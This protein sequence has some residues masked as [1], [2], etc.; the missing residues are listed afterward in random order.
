MFD[1]ANLEADQTIENDDSSK[2]DEGVDNQVNSIPEWKELVVVCVVAFKIHHLNLSR[3]IGGFCHI[4]FCKWDLTV[5]N[6]DV[7]V[8]QEQSDDNE[9]LAKNDM[10]Y[11]L[12]IINK[13]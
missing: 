8:H 4:V 7:Q 1:C 5:E 12:L 9:L 13:L 2:R 6:K 10:I 11:K 3:Y